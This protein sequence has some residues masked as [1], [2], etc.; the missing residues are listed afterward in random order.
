MTI[1]KASNVPLNKFIKFLESE[2]LT[3]IRVTGGHYIYSRVDL[4][5]PIPLQSHIDPVPEF[6]VL[7]ILKTLD[8]NT[9]QMWERIDKEKG[10]KERKAEYARRGKR[11]KK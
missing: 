11:R 2:R 5:R 6:I 10:T 1:R 7:E 8:M 4:D 3:Q 9:D